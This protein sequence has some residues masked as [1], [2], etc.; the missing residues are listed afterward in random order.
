MSAYDPVV[1]EPDYLE[2]EDPTVEI[3]HWYDDS[4]W[5]VQFVPTAVAF[6]AGLLVGAA[7]ALLALRLLGEDD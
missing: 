5:R 4:P 6:T 1:D 3:V 7:G 2:D